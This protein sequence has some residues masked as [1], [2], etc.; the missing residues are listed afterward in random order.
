MQIEVVSARF[1]NGVHDYWFS[2][3]G[4]GL[5][6]GDYVIVDTE[7]GK[8]IVRITKAVQMVD[9]GQLEGALKNVLK[10]AN[11]KELK[12]GEEN[13]KKAAGLYDEIKAMA[14]AEKLEMK[15][16][17]VECNYNF[18]R[19]TVNFTSEDRVDFRDLVKK[20]ADKYKT[21]IEL[22]QIGPRDATR[23]L[24]GLG[25]CGK[26]C[27]CKEGFGINDHVS[28][29][30]AKNQGLSL[31][32]NNISGLCGKLLCCLA[33][34]NPYYV[35]VMKT[36][37]KVNTRVKTPDGEG[38]VI[39]NDLLKKKVSVKFENDSSS[40]VKVFEVGDIKF[41]NHTEK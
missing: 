38:V 11:E 30:M 8:D 31:N 36:M 10:K 37:P 4:L 3:N 28:I 6:V 32:P 15:V 9:E 35:E 29:K 41:K 39:F 22:R 23:L 27:C 25:V 12:E 2:P 13:Y 14:K 20:L 17:N 18:S 33:Y 26:V 40:E 7:K 1:R 34:E 16:I 21:R 19:L 5:S 24:G